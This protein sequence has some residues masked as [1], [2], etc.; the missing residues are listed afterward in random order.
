MLLLVIEI[1]W[2][3]F[4]IIWVFRFVGVCLLE[5]FFGN[6]ICGI[7]SVGSG[8]M[9]VK[10][11][12]LL[13]LIDFFFNFRSKLFF[14]CFIFLLFK[15]IGIFKIF[16]F[17]LWVNFLFFF[18]VIFWN[19]FLRMLLSFRV[20]LFFYFLI[21]WNVCCFIFDVYLGLFVRGEIEVSVIFCL[22]FFFFYNLIVVLIVVNWLLLFFDEMF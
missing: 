16:G 12:W 9:W 21:L 18:V 2:E 13:F 17:F 11:L 7:G 22:V 8:G 4:F 6:L 5:F 10:F 20:K 1:W 14:N 3:S 15:F 19:C